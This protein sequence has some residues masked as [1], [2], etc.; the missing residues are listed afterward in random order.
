[1][2]N[3]DGTSGTRVS[4]ALKPFGTSVFAEMTALATK[5]QAVNLAQ[6]FPDFD[7]PEFVK[8]AATA[9][10]GA[11]HNQYAR[12][13]G[14]PALN[15]AIARSWR[16]RGFDTLGEI[17]ADSWVTVTTG[18]TQAIAS[19]MLGLLDPG[20]EVILF[21]PFYDSYRPCLAMARAVP[22]V[23]NLRP[24]KAWGVGAREG[25]WFDEDELRRAIGPKTRAIL[26]NTP[27]NPTGKVFTQIELE[28][29]ARLCVEHD[30]L[31]FTDEVYEHLIYDEGAEHVPIAILDG[32][33]ERTV[34]MSSLGKSFSLTGWKI[35][36]VVATPRL[37]AGVRAAH[38]FL[39]YGAA[40]PLQYAAAVALTNGKDSIR[41]LVSLLKGNRDLL[42]GALERQGFKV[43]VPAAS[44]FIMAD[45]SAFGFEDDWDFCRTLTREVGVA[46]I[47]PSAFY[48]DGRDARHLVR[49]AFC[50]KPKTMEAAIERLARLTPRAKSGAR[51]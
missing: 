2:S 9:A 24:P 27:H 37:T 5:H 25:F 3:T 40:T 17:E 20:D 32:M 47:P 16:E 11:G 7:G 14:V 35:G 19:T 39:T 10:I 33:R 51:T 34:T 4:G 22:R 23:V 31:A 15:E 28:S 6:G 41:A 44:Y 1:M 45:H 49:F 13:M 30:L 38:Q 12:M 26:I 21:E 42:A 46:A 43:C 50:K 36:W 48:Q 29:I 18:C 8:Q